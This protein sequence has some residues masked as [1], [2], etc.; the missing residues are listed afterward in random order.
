MAHKMVQ[1]NTIQLWRNLQRQIFLV[2]TVASVATLS[3][4]FTLS[5]DENI[6][7]PPPP[8]SKAE[9]SSTPQEKLINITTTDEGETAFTPPKIASLEEKKAPSQK[10]TTAGNK[11]SSRIDPE[12]FLRMTPEQRKAALAAINRKSS[13]EQKARSEQHKKFNQLASEK[14]WEAFLEISEPRLSKQNYETASVL[15]AAIRNKAPNWVFRALLNGGAKFEYTHTF[16]VIRMEDLAFTQRLVALGLDIHAQS[17]NGEN[18]INALAE[19]PYSTETLEYLLQQNVAIVMPQNSKSPVTVALTKAVKID[20]AV[21]FAAK[22]L[23][24]GANPSA[25]DYAL[26]EE[27]KQQ[28]PKAYQLVQA[29]IPELI[30]GE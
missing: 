15:I 7:M 3:L 16:R 20:Q 27:L 10:Q 6:G 17:H 9:V 5:S 21:L 8:L 24:Y 1:N 13:P 11:N 14:N 29:H 12:E 2:L 26:V 18:A 25:E 30:R 19:L 23:Q 4:W 22:L 28:N